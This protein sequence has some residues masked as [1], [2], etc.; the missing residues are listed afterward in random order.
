MERKKLDLWKEWVAQQHRQ[1]RM[2]GEAQWF[3][4]LLNTV[5]QETVSQT[6]EIPGVETHVE[7]EKVLGTEDILRVRDV[8]RTQ[9]HPQPYMKTVLT[10]K[11][12]ILILAL[13]IEQ[14]ELERSLQ[15]KE[16]YLDEL[17]DKL[18]N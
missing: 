2:Y 12:W 16:L 17:L 5:Q 15:E 9:L 1:M 4:H 8:P 13:V 7:V 3:Q 10:A 6:R 11:T 18:C 14:C